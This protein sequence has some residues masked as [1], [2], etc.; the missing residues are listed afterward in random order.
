MSLLE[1]ALAYLYTQRKK[2]ENV[3][4]DNNYD[5]IVIYGNLVIEFIRC[6][7]EECRKL[8]TNKNLSLGNAFSYL[9][10]LHGNSNEYPISAFY[11]PCFEEI[12]M[13]PEEV[14]NMINTYCKVFTEDRTVIDQ[15]TKYEIS[16]FYWVKLMVPLYYKY[17]CQNHQPPPTI[18]VDIVKYKSF[19]SYYHEFSEKVIKTNHVGFLYHIKQL[20]ELNNTMLHTPVMKET[21][22]V[23]VTPKVTPTVTPKVTPAVKEKKVAVKRK[24]EKIPST[25]RKIVWNTYMGETLFSKCLCCGVEEISVNNFECGHVKSEK[26]GGQITIDNLRPICG[27]CN[28]SIATRNM[29]EFMLKYGIKKPSNWDGVN[30]I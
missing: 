10:Q 4:K 25:V 24:K 21:P 29:E 16:K 11:Q 8:A 26:N 22:T 6:I 19:I 17:I 14:I 15:D 13:Y 9:E 20:E 2:Y 3:K 12:N 1:P 5:F 27:H 30:N 28:K 23:T 7:T 18:L